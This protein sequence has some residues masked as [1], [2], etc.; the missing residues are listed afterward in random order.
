MT[1]PGVYEASHIKPPRRRATCS[2]MDERPESLIDYAQEHGLV[3]VRGLYYQAEVRGVPGIDRDDCGY[4][5]VQQQV[6]APHHEGRL[7]DVTDATR[8][9][10]E[11]VTHDSIEGALRETAR[12]YLKSLWHDAGEVVTQGRVGLTHARRCYVRR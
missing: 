10:R 5:E 2:E 9:L 11:P 1:M 12:L 3:T 7:R 8:W 4:V 6:L